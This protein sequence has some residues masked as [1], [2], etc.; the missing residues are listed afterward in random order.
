MIRVKGLARLFKNFMAI[1]IVFG[2][3]FAD[4]DSAVPAKF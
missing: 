1:P 3:F 2:T 4:K